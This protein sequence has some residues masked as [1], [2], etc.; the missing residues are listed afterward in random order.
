MGLRY[1]S[2]DSAS[3][4]QAMRQ[5]LAIANQITD[6]LSNGCDH[7][8]AT[9][10][11]GE[12]K[13]AAYTAGREL[14]SEVMIPTIKQLQKA[15]DDIEGELR[16][17][18]YADSTISGYG[19]LDLENLERQIDVKWSQIDLIDEQLLQQ[20]QFLKKITALA[21][22]NLF[23]YQSQI[24]ALENIKS[25]LQ[26]DINELDMRVEKLKWFAS[27]VS[28]YFSDS[29][30]VLQLAIQGALA[31][32]NISLDSSGHYYS[33]GTNMDWLKN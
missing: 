26:T 33:N 13:G 6:R 23:Q 29:L 17:Y 3:L 21:S 2:A 19:T 25:Q 5:N 12:L 8:I 22:G 1:S 28:R 24:T 7:L 30:N 15:I 14:F 20:R 16:S 11:S 4:M 32:D 9:L 31:L 27:D 10:D 18:Q